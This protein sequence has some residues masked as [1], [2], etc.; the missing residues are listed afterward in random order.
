MLRVIVADDTGLI[1]EIPVTNP[2]D[3]RKFRKQDREH[4]VID[5]SLHGTEVH[6]LLQGWTL[7]SLTPH[8]CC[9]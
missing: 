9:L 5:L 7:P 2:K 8:N 6:Q 1:K 3:Q 4:V